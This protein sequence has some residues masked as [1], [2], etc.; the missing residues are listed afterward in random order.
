[1]PTFDTPGPV[2]VTVTLAMGDVRVIASDRTDTVVDIRPAS[3][4]AKSQKMAEQTT[5][6]HVD[7]RVTIRTPKGLALMLGRPGGVDVDILVPSGSRLEGDTGMGDLVVEGRLGAC[8]FKSGMGALRLGDTGPLDV[9]T[10]FGE[11][12]VVAVDGDADVVTG[13]GELRLGRV[14][15]S[16]TVKNSNGGVHVDEVGRGSRLT[17]SNGDISVGRVS[18]GVTAK[19]ARGSIRVREAKNGD[20]VLQTALGE[21]EIG[22]PEGTAAWLDLQTQGIVHNSLTEAGGPAD[23]DEQVK[24]RART[25]FG[26]ISIHRSHG[27]NQ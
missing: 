12:S 11:V 13:S 2:A 8:R 1:M 22:I 27:R 24:I 10:G 3:G 25:S 6:D 9:S 18:G 5:V 20:V 16:A 14:T 15:G 19:T 17:T 26:D 7:G 23:T 21:V 4:S